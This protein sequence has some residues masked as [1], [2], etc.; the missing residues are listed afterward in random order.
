[1]PARGKRVPLIR[2]AVFP[3]FSCQPGPGPICDGPGRVQKTRMHRGQTIEHGAFEV[4][5]TVHVCKAGCRHPSGYPVT[6]RAASVGE[7]LMPCRGVGYDVMVYVGKE[8]FLRPR[9]RE[10]IRTTLNVEHGISLST[11]KISDLHGT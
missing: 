1:M 8:R 9:Q 5:E 6:R 3:A 10:E 7:L 4:R 2:C 11:G